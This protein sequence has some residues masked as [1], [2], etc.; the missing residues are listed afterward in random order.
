MEQFKYQRNNK[1]KEPNTHTNCSYK[2]ERLL[3]HSI[4]GLFTFDIMTRRSASMALYCLLFCLFFFLFKFSFIS[5]SVFVLGSR[6]RKGTI[7]YVVSLCAFTAQIMFYYRNWNE[8]K[9]FIKYKF[10]SPQK[11]NSKMNGKNE[12]ITTWENVNAIA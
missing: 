7:E 11:G 2:P 5:D 9:C 10:C 6:Q 12:T 4:V 8:F 1:K 3:L